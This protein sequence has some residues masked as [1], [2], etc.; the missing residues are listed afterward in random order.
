LMI[1]FMVPTKPDLG[2]LVLSTQK[3]ILEL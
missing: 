3:L 2:G 1:S